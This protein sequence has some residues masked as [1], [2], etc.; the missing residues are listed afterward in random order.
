MSS[1][2]NN[3]WENK[4]RLGVSFTTTH[5]Q[6]PLAGKLLKVAPR[7]RPH[8][9][10]QPPLRNAFIHHPH[11]ASDQLGSSTSVFPPLQPRVKA[12]KPSCLVNTV[13][14]LRSP[15]NLVIFS[16]G[17]RSRRLVIFVMLFQAGSHRKEN[18][19]TLTSCGS[20]RVVSSRSG[21][22]TMQFFKCI[23]AVAA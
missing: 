8:G 17:Y 4:S 11:L 15:C 14:G 23:H 6:C 20:L 12:P 18:E 1:R 3:E 10:W 7:A 16:I 13:S 9:R 2:E 5:V 22:A 19:S 21:K